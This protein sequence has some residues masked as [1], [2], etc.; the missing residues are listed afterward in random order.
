VS[1]VAALRLI[2]DALPELAAARTEQA[3][4]R[5]YAVLVRDVAHEL[6]PPRRSRSYP[7][8]VK[9]KMS[10]FKLKRPAVHGPQLATTPFLDTVK[11]C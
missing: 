3:R 5:R 2:R 9:R 10:K 7:R 11:I 6:N 8:V 1:F 4:A